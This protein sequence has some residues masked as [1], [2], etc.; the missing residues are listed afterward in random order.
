MGIARRAFLIGSIGVAGALVV[1][2]RWAAGD[3]ANP[4]VATLKDNEAALTPYVK[5]GADGVITAIVPYA[6]MGQGVSTT[7]AALVAEELDIALADL[8]VEHGPA[9]GA[10]GNRAIVADISPFTDETA[11]T[12]NRLWN[13]IAALAAPMVGLQVTGSSTST[14]DAFDC[15]RQAAA[16]ARAMLVEAASLQLNVASA[17]L[18]TS[19]GRVI[20]QG[21]GRSLSYGEL[22]AQAAKL[23]VPERVKL[24]PK[25]DWVTL[26]KS[27]QRKDGLAKVTGAA[28][29]GIDVD[30]PDMLH[31]T[32]LMAPRFGAKLGGIKDDEAKAVKGF[33]K[34][35]PLKTA[36]GNGVAVI[37]ENTW[38]A[39]QAAEALEVEWLSE[40]EA[41]NDATLTALL[42]EGI[43]TGS[44]WSLAKTG[45][46]TAKLD[47]ST[48][49]NLLTL[50]YAVPPLAHATMEPMNAT[51]Q[52]KDGKLTIWGP[53]QAPSLVQLAVGN[54][55]DIPF[56][57][58]TINV[59]HLGGGF[60]R[61]AEV[62]FALFAAIAAKETDGRP[63]QLTWRREEDFTHDTY[64]A[65]AQARIRALPGD[66]GVPEALEIKI[67]TH[68][69]TRSIASRILPSLPMAGPDAYLA[70]GAFD[71]P[72][73]LKAF[74]V[75]GVDVPLPL[76]AGY[77]RSVGY[78]H[79]TFF[80]ESALDEVAV[81]VS[82]DPLKQRLALLEG[83]TAAQGVLARAAELAGWGSEGIK[84]G[85]AYV[86]AYDSHAAMIVELSGNAE[87]I[88]IDRIIVVADVGIAL[89]PGLVADQLVSATVMG[90]SA[91]M[92]EKIT[93][94]NG[95]VNEANYDSYNVLRI[96]G[97]PPIITEVLQTGVKPGGVGELAT[98][99]VAPALANAIFKLTGNRIRIL[100][101]AGSVSFS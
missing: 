100:P 97:C 5:I 19:G 70:E 9:S 33:Q 98:P 91:A 13:G 28:I 50:D 30:L 61:R 84:Q 57:D 87:T 32:V 82:A 22:A 52:F 90:L 45:D 36:Y 23:P 48:N 78:S 99:L 20:H 44:G 69:V 64:R 25:D 11:P 83:N 8:Q 93:L 38:A 47:G 59:T 49:R 46:A 60:G 92:G 39:F 29:F 58:I 89:D 37:A 67:A 62:D 42:D 85:L 96:S 80:I 14:R 18:V 1:G 71:V 7:L 74:H 68:S 79:N 72:F 40:G 10:Y 34:L 66:D 77:W 54:V 73:R 65:P 53:I 88:T 75:E 51:A 27:Q 12:L 17:A 26:G 63:V 76:P 3:R 56:A 101:F 55:L 86:S 43:K 95:A 2:W 21:S 81:R 31:G 15:M 41:A 4:L 24:K 94:T 16:T 35:I 6:E